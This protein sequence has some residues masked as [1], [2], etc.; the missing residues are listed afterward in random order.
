M[1]VWNDQGRGLGERSYIQGWH[2]RI[3][4]QD[5]E[6]VSHYTTFVQKLMV[7]MEQFKEF[8]VT[9]DVKK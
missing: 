5:V 8:N 6:G 1:Q 2:S 3:L 9:L 4:G 7:D